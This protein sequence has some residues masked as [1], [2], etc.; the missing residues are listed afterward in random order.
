[1]NEEK[2][3]EK[4]ASVLK[5]SIYECKKLANEIKKITKDTELKQV[6]R[7]VETYPIKNP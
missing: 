2:V 6:L 4:I 3:I 1:M 7:I 5:I